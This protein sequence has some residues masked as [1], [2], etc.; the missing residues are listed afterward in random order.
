MDKPLRK[1]RELPTLDRLRELLDYDPATG[2]FRWR[3]DRSPKTRAGM[4][5]GAVTPH[6][7]ITITVDW[8]AF[9]AHQLAWLYVY[10]EAAN[11]VDHK[12][13]S[14]SDNRIDNLR[15]SSQTQNRANSKRISRR[16]YDLPKGVV[17]CGKRFQAQ[18][19]FRSKRTVI[20]YFDSPEEASTAYQVMAEVIFGEF[21]RRA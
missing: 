17:P 20:G 12:N 4:I 15:P 8:V 5:A 19:Y 6:G 14:R 11:Q 2:I 10:G 21:A 9:F 7:Y 16:K 13:G 3:V 18:I 1:R